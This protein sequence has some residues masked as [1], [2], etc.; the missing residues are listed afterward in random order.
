MLELSSLYFRLGF[1]CGF[2]P[3]PQTSPYLYIQWLCST[4]LTISF[5]CLKENPLGDLSRS[6]LLMLL[7]YA[8]VVRKAC[9][10]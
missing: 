6:A 7:F 4:E 8:T 1:C 9:I 3:P 5:K 2:R 10:I